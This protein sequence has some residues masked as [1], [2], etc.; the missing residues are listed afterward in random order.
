[1]GR[2]YGFARGAGALE[3]RHVHNDRVA[4][5]IRPSPWPELDRLARF[6]RASDSLTD[7]LAAWTGRGLAVEV[8]NRVDGVCPGPLVDRRAR[9]ARRRARAGPG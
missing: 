3:S 9:A 8:L 4:A 1:M 7:T 6:V 5:M 2:H